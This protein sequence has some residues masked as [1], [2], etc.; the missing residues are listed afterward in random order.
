MSPRGGRGS[1]ADG[2][3]DVAVSLER[4]EESPAVEVEVPT[5]PPATETAGKATRSASW[6]RA[7]TSI[8]RAALSSAS[9]G[10]KATVE[11]LVISAQPDGGLLIEP[12]N[13]GNEVHAYGDPM[14]P[15]G[16]TVMEVTPA[17]PPA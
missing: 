10:R 16:V 5:S 11:R 12:S 2:A 6:H 13:P 1:G 17:E 4:P 7:V 3:V 15:A 8:S 9:H 14:D